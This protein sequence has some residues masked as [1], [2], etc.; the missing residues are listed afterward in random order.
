ML[1]CFSNNN[2]KYSFIADPDDL[3]TSDI[4]TIFLDDNKYVIID[5]KS[6]IIKKCNKYYNI[7]N[8]SVVRTL[9]NRRYLLITTSYEKNLWYIVEYNK[10]YMGILPPK[11]P[12]NKISCN[13]N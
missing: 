4:R 11:I 9:T 5:K 2:I 13:K 7:W 8:Y 3:L 10:E 12:F 1:C 6:H